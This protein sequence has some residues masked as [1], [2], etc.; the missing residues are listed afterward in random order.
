MSDDA[1]QVINE[2]LKKTMIAI[3]R[4]RKPCASGSQRISRDELK[5]LA[6]ECC[7]RLGIEWH[8]AGRG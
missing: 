1:G 2:E 8:G 5:T 4:G 6:R 3:A 7:D